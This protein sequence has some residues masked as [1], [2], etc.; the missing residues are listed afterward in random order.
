MVRAV[1]TSCSVARSERAVASAP[2][3]SSAP[4]IPVSIAAPPAPICTVAP[5]GAA[6]RT[7]CTAPIASAT[8]M[9]GLS[10]SVSS[11]GRKPSA[12]QPRALTNCVAAMNV[13]ADTEP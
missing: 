5:T 2:V 11:V 3:P 7:R 1:S 8:W 12:C 13:T 9:P 10:S 6:A 4:G